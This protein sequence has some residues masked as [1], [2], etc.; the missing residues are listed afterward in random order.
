[1]KKPLLF[2]FIM[3]LF[4]LSFTGCYRAKQYIYFQNLKAKADTIKSTLP[5]SVQNSINSIIIQPF[6]QLDIR[7]KTSVKALESLTE[8]GSSGSA[9]MGGNNTL[10]Q[11]SSY[12]T[13]FQVDANGN[14]TL[15][16]LG[17]IYLRG[18]TIKQAKDRIR[19]KMKI[20]M[21][22]PYVD[23]K[24]L[25]FRV[26]VLGEVVSPGP[27][28][29]ANE[30]A[31]LIDLISQSGDLTDNANRK[32]IKIIRGDP[33][34]PEVYQIDLTNTKS[35]YSPGFILQP[36]DIIYVEPLPRKFLFQNLNEAV[37]FFTIVNTVL[38]VYELLHQ[39]GVF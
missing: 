21:T 31:D 4:A 35:F 29:V 24:F 11:S 18:L 7:I 20:Y 1:M 6:D 2:I 38:I 12:L 8:S 13:G 16:E 27:R 39:V 25:T 22:D 15:P 3:G 19:E 34:S 10:T 30:R 36:N 14:V 17:N 28:P 5:D 9:L 33:R 32:T 26:T 37:P 23:I